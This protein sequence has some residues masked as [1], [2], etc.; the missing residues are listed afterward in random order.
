MWVFSG[1]HTKAAMKESIYL[2]VLVFSAVY[3]AVLK[4]GLNQNSN[5]MKR[6]LSRKGWIKKLDGMASHIVLKRWSLCPFP[7]HH[8]PVEST[9]AF[10]WISRRHLI[11][12]W[13]VDT[14]NIIGSCWPCNCNF[15]GRWGPRTGTPNQAPFW[16]WY[17][18]NFSIEAYNKLQATY[19]AIT[20][21]DISDLEIIGQMLESKVNP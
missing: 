4:I 10:H 18:S 1:Y 19:H 6:R 11:V 20:D 5:L 17:K 16:D 14:P 21:Y 9:C 15:S 2:S 12:R 13:D 3:V 8:M 7:W